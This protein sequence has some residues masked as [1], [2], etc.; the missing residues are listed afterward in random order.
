MSINIKIEKNKN[1]NNLSMIKRFS[2]KMQESGIINKVKSERYADR[3]KS[4]F[5]KK[6]NKLKT[7]SKKAEFEKMF[8]LGKITSHSRR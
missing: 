2:R 7:L 5:V 4:D 3:N 6:K 1:E 8:K